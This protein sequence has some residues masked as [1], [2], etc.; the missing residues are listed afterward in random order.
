MAKPLSGQANVLLRCT[1][2]LFKVDLEGYRRKV[3]AMK[4][5]AGVER[6]DLAIT[7]TTD[8]KL[9]QLNHTYRQIDR[10]TDILSFP[11]YDKVLFLNSIEHA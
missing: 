7:L 2:R 9:R 6:W 8:R 3:V 11:F 1:Q 10:P 5:V 4:A